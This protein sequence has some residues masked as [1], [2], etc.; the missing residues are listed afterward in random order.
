MS[1]GLNFLNCAAGACRSCPL[2]ELPQVP[3]WGGW[4]AGSHVTI[5]TS[6]GGMRERTDAPEPHQ[7]VWSALATRGYY[8][9]EGNQRKIGFTTTFQVLVVLEH[10]VITQRAVGQCGSSVSVR[11]RNLFI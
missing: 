8:I 10:L 7:P 3:A 9:N 1:G 11:Q 5:V 2:K 4:V 6:R